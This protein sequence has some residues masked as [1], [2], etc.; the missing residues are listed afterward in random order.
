MVKK[1]STV[2][3]ID[4]Y[5]ESTIGIPPVRML[6]N[7][8]QAFNPAHYVFWLLS[9]AYCC[10]VSLYAAFWLERSVTL[11]D[12]EEA[13]F[14]WV[15]FLCLSVIITVVGRSIQERDLG[16]I[17]GCII[18]VFISL[19]FF[20]FYSAGYQFQTSEVS[21]SSVNAAISHSEARYDFGVLNRNEN[22]DPVNKKGE[23]FEENTVDL[24]ID[25]VAALYNVDPELI[26]AVITIESRWNP[27]AVSY[28]GA[29][30]LMQ[31][32]PVVQDRY[33]VEDPFN[34]R[35]NIRA[36]TAYLAELIRRYGL[37]NG[38]AAYNAGP[39]RVEQFQ[40]VPRIRETQEYVKKVQREYRRRIRNK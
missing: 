32:M 15:V 40:G 11:Q 14:V 8:L 29:K 5:V 28:K 17:L 24:Y 1:M 20:G 10:G 27:N 23:A 4:Y 7:I 21:G 22:P 25:E 30:G 6:S 26:R 34:P 35:E 38:L 37:T 19:I 13:G 9:L 36:G 16:G 18:G 2:E 39:V 12:L 3:I 33:N 31:L